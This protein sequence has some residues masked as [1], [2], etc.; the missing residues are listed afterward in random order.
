MMRRIVAA[1]L[2]ESEMKRRK[3]VIGLSILCALAL[4]AFVASGASAQEVFTCAKNGGKKDF[5]AGDTHCSKGHVA[6]GTG[7][8]GHVAFTGK[9]ATSVVNEGNFKLKSK[10]AGLEIVFQA[11]SIE[12]NGKIE[13]V[14]KNISAIGFLIFKNVTVTV[15]A[16][17]GC[18]VESI[19]ATVGE[20]A[21]KEVIHSKELATVNMGLTNEIGFQPSEGKTLAEYTVK[22][23]TNN[24]FNGTYE[25]EGAFRG[26]TSGSTIAFTHANTTAEGALF[27]SGQ[28]AG[29][30]GSLT[31]KGANG[32]GLALT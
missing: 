19:P 21:T 3:A 25:L 10:V 6:E 26:L 22:K 31:F 24:E 9:T 16:K 18:E 29:V 15:P 7:E 11:T 17:S 30:E 4:G 27:L 13:N 28:H 5:G 32:N 23:C 20:V 12:G 8:Y 14:A 2:K 1:N